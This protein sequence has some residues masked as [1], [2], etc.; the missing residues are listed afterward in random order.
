MTSQQSI[1]DVFNF[2]L[3]DRAEIAKLD[4]ELEDEAKLA[5]E[6]WQKIM[7]NINQCLEEAMKI[8]GAIGAALVD[9]NSG[10]CLGTAGG[11]NFNLE[12]AAAGNTEVVRSKLKVMQSLGLKDHIE[13]ILISLGNQYHLIRLSSDHPDLFLYLVLNRSQAN[14]ALARYKLSQLDPLLK[15]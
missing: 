2:S 6:E 15:L 7:S 11:G 9:W 8:E 10:M 3:E 12:I 1:L 5:D 4:L 13:D 14:L